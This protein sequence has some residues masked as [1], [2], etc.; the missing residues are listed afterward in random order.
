[1][2]T[3]YN[4]V[5]KLNQAK[6]QRQ[7]Q[8][9]QAYEDLG[10][11]NPAYKPIQTN[12]V[13]ASP[14]RMTATI[15]QLEKAVVNAYQGND[16]YTPRKAVA[17]TTG[18]LRQTYNAQ[19]VSNGFNST[20]GGGGGHTFGP[21]NESNWDKI[22]S[23]LNAK[24]ESLNALN[25]VDYSEARQDYAPLYNDIL[26]RQLE[27]KFRRAGINS[28][29]D[30]PDIITQSTI[31]GQGNGMYGKPTPELQALG[32]TQ[33]DMQRYLDPR[34]IAEAEAKA[35]A[36]AE[37]HPVLATG[38][39]AVSNP[40][41]STLGDIQQ[42]S[43]RIQGKPLT[44]SYSPST[45]MRNTVS[46]GIDSNL[47]R[48]AYGGA[49]SVAD[50][51]MALLLSK[52]LGGGNNQAVA[53]T[54]AGIMGAEKANDT[55][56]SAIERGL[57]PNQV[58]AEGI[59]SAASTYL[60]EMA[61]G[62]LENIAGGQGN[63]LM[64]MLSEGAQE[65]LE[66]IIDTLFDQAITLEGGNVEKSELAQNY[67]AYINAGYS[68]DDAKAQVVKDYINQVGIDVALGGI[69]GGLMQGGSNVMSGRN[70]ITGNLTQRNQ[71]QIINSLNAE[72][73]APENFNTFSQA[74][75]NLKE[76]APE[77][78]KKLDSLKNDVSNQIINDVKEAADTVLESLDPN[79]YNEFVQNAEQIK[80][81]IPA[82]ESDIDNILA[83]FNNEFVTLA[84][85]SNI[86][87]NADN[88]NANVDNINNNVDT[89]ANVQQTL[90]VDQPTVQTPE[91]KAPE[92][93]ASRVDL[94]NARRTTDGLREKLDYFSSEVDTQPLMN[95][96][97]EA[98][99][100]VVN[101]RG[102]A[103][104]DAIQNLNAVANRINETM[105]GT[106]IGQSARD[107][108]EEGYNNVRNVTDGRRIAITPAQLE[109][110]GYRTLRELN[111]AVYTGSPK[112]VKFYAEG[113]LNTVPLDNVYAEMRDLA[114]G[115]L[116]D[117]TEGDQLNALVNYI[118]QYKSGKNDTV[119]LANWDRMNTDSRTDSER[120]VDDIADTV[121]DSIDDGD[122]T[123]EQMAQVFNM[124]SEIQS[125][126]PELAGKISQV[127]QDLWEAATEQIANASVYDPEIDAAT[128]E[129]IDELVEEILTEEVPREH[130]NSSGVN[131]GRMKRSDLYENTAKKGGM[132]NDKIRE[133]DTKYGHMMYAENHEQE[134]MD[135]A[136]RRLKRDG[137][138]KAVRGLMKK[139]GWTNVDTDEMMMIY[140]DAKTYAES[141]DEQ[142]VDSD[143]AWGYCYDILEKIKEEASREGQ[144]L[145]ALAK[146]SR[147]NTPEGL[148][149][150]ATAII[151]KASK[152]SV[153]DKEVARETKN[154]Y[155]YDGKGPF[156][157]KVNAVDIDFMKK[158]LAEAKKLEPINSGERLN[159]V[160]NELIQ[161]GKTK[162]Q[163]QRQAE[164]IVNREYKHIY[165]NLGKL[166]N[167]QIPSGAVER[168]R[169]L[170][171]DNM[172]G[173]VRTLITRNAGGNVGFNLVEQ[174][175]RKPL[176][177]LID[178]GVS[179]ARGSG[180]TVGD[181]SLQN[182]KAYGQGAKEAFKQEWYD[183][184]H[185]VHSARS[186]EN[187]L[188]TAVGN[189]RTVF[190]NNKTN[191]VKGL[192][193][194]LNKADNLVRYGLSVGDRWAYEATY[195]QT[196]AELQRLYEDG[197]LDRKFKDKNGNV[198]TERMSQEEFKEWAEKQA[199]I[200]ALE[201][202]Y[203][204]DSE[205]AQGFLAARKLVN[206]VSNAI[207]G[208]DVLS[209]FTI[210]FAKT[211]ANIIQR[212]IEYSP[213]G[214]AKNA[215]QT[216]K[217]VRSNTGLDQRRF[218]THT[219]R[220]IIGSALWA[221]GIMAAKS[222]LLTGGYDE[223]DDMRAAQK[224]AGMQ[225]YALNLGDKNVSV[226]WIPVLGNNAVAAA[227]FYDSFNNPELFLSQRLEQ[228]ISAGLKSQFESSALQGLNRFIAGSGYNNNEG[229]IVSN[230]KDT[231]KSGVTQFVPSLLRQAAAFS[232]D[233]RRQLSGANPD[234]YYRNSFF[235]SIPG[236]RFRES[237]EPRI[238]MTGEY[239]EQNPGRTPFQ[240]FMDNFVN[241]ATVTMAT[242]DRVR[243]EAMRLYQSTGNVAAFQTAV[244][245]KNLKL[246][247]H[248]PT[249][250][251]FT[252][253]QRNAYTAMNEIAGNF[254]DSDYYQSLNDGDKETALGEIYSAI[255]SVE[256][257]NVIDADKSTL[258]GAAK[259]YDQGGE[260]GLID[261]VVARNALAA[262]GRT[263]NEKNREEILEVLEQSGTDGIQQMVSHSNDLT[264]AGIDTYNLQKKYDHAVQT[265]P[266]LTPAQF[267]ETWDE[268]DGMINA[269]DSVS[270]DEMLAYLNQN[271]GSYDL[272]EVLQ[273]WNAYGDDWSYQ[274][275]WDEKDGVWK[276]HK[277]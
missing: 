117:V 91:V 79:A 192:N 40:I 211:P 93:R 31:M 58:L 223:D 160:V 251:E 154:A 29:N 142:G 65:G 2:A 75:D 269:N 217:E 104:I 32:I 229:D 172:L 185:G 95:E 112:S 263:N 135:E 115:E 190:K 42:I 46:E 132:V 14:Q 170:L 64:S 156:A 118:T 33:E 257:R 86:K 111:S 122:V 18:N 152:G 67:N 225:E 247:G 110:T 180:R 55:M 209:Q 88:V 268:I 259:A 22:K 179:K 215:I 44:Q 155:R 254:I 61:L 82:L 249:P 24:P 1:M 203:Q 238:T 85:E 108:N 199:K 166:I 165:D 148:L 236:E 159:E 232:D 23:S 4:A 69:T 176:S 130:N 15:P 240:K 208:V 120:R 81:Q 99:D 246:D 149:A 196:L 202:C 213:L 206:K 275:Y 28:V 134:S 78:S 77:M 125:K 242:P 161:K 158:F 273:Y 80:A 197:K 98:Y 200:N 204:D 276:K 140:H 106:T 34:R 133:Q 16:S 189:N 26:D 8:L 252:R 121:L 137:E 222:G 131:T 68:E 150:E 49:N 17:P 261:Y 221:L 30:L 267:M 255:I 181:V 138:Q 37:S 113:A 54:A 19:R 35:Q 195:S 136:S 214:L 153:W 244:E 74:V 56:N 266:S 194:I 220:N 10:G 94:S 114:N 128:E 245:W 233:Y 60:S 39:A 73:V 262:L 83:D 184:T 182:Y 90:N 248:E 123:A 27:Q 164:S 105:S 228:G 100:R 102:Q 6:A 216:I 89:Q 171:M 193:Y 124:L 66:D 7:A 162:E 226:D 146:W 87:A 256:S 96:L 227:A 5:K 163:A 107:I 231:L 201:A 45:I 151:E 212:A 186:G 169:T 147:S 144:A 265:I 20:H 234:D 235:N 127:Y 145:Q 177:A 237:L 141:L 253:F 198:T 219:A 21:S 36:F 241:P 129:D 183:F 38:A 9:A 210:P 260:D 11:S 57:N 205:M 62:P 191:S 243:D 143:E 178:A 72:E 116:P 277:T 271:P 109:S 52:A 258:N 119:E 139:T 174:L 63:V 47:G 3:N 41:E 103:Q 168:V 126:N 207:I 84:S 50:M 59:G 12:N 71:N 272:N 274:P 101:S 230:A 188:S 167:T 97:N 239:M 92:I 13:L 51:G 48:I 25:H 187:N 173:N 218:S 250:E 53:R 70:A 224:Q 270:Q 43:D 157:K 175:L 264:E 76:N